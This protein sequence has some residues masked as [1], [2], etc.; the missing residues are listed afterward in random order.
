MNILFIIIS[1][2]FIVPDK[3]VREHYDTGEALFDGD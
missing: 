2:E 3:G 1:E